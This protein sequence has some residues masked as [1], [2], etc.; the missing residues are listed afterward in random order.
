MPGS[1]KWPLS[2]RFP[3]QNPEYGSPLPHTRYMPPH[4]ILLDFITC[5]ILGKQ[6]RS[7][8]SSHVS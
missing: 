1:P 2:L 7:L 3:Y 8:S 4:L 5:T 6:Y